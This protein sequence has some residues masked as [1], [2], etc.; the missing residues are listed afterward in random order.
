METKGIQSLYNKRGR[1]KMNKTNLNINSHQKNLANEYMVKYHYEKI[2]IENNNSSQF[3]CV[4]K[5]I[6]QLKN[7]SKSYI[8]KIIEY[9]RSLYYY[10]LKKATLSLNKY[11]IEKQIKTILNP[12]HESM[13]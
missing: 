6:H 9:T 5:L 4:N 10:N 1:P 2:K 8:L 12:C 13:D 11:G 3:V 7:F